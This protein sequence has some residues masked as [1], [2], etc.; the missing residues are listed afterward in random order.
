MP[1]H[2]ERNGQVVGPPF[3]GGTLIDIVG[4][5]Q[6]EDGRDDVQLYLEDFD[7]DLQFHSHQSRED[8]LPYPGALVDLVSFDQWQDGGEEL[9][10]FRADHGEAVHIHLQEISENVPFPGELVYVLSVEQREEDFVS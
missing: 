1:F 6:P 3:D 5:Q 2:L 8:V 9:P 10:L 7:D 4:V